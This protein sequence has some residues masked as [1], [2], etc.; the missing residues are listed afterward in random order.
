[1]A[2]EI[3]TDLFF[4][5]FPNFLSKTNLSNLRLC[6]QWRQQVR[7]NFPDFATNHNCSST[8]KRQFLGKINFVIFLPLFLKFLTVLSN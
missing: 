1:M 3:V 2:L 8:K 5:V 4:D 7:V 6:L